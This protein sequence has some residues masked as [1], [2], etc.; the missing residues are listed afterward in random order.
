MENLK[1]ALMNLQFKTIGIAKIHGGIEL[2]IESDEY[3]FV[4][5][6]IG[7]L[8]GLATCHYSKQDFDFVQIPEKYGNLGSFLYEPCEFSVWF[9]D[10]FKN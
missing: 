10:N 6:S 8:G 4:T 5:I 7:D 1:N 2:V 3:S 9:S